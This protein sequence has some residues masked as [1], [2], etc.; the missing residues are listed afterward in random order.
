MQTRRQFMQNNSFLILGGIFSSATPATYGININKFPRDWVRLQGK[1]ITRY[2]KF[3]HKL[4]LRNIST[5][6]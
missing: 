3:I 5:I 4:K 1:E 2:G 6:V